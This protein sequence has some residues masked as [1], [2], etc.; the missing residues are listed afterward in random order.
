MDGPPY[1]PAVP[2]AQILIQYAPNL[3]LLALAGLLP[4]GAVLVQVRAPDVAVV[5]RHR[6]VGQHPV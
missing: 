4:G 6:A 3:V 1:L 2:S 5:A